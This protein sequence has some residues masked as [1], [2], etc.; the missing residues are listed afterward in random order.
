ME[1]ISDILLGELEVYLFGDNY[2][3][4]V[5]LF[6]FSL[7]Q[8]LQLWSTMMIW[9]GKKF[10]IIYTK[11]MPLIILLYLLDLVLQHAR[12]IQV[13][14]INKLYHI[15]FFFFFRSRKIH[16]NYILELQFMT[17]IPTFCEV[18]ALSGHHPINHAQNVLTA[19]N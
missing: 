19:W 11:K 14:K 13:R 1:I 18:M 8:C 12:Q 4:M 2:V 17:V 6:A 9:D 10:A 7:C 5:F 15:Q 3:L 16:L